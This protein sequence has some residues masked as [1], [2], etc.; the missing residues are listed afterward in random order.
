[1]L[2]QTRL[3]MHHK[4]VSHEPIFSPGMRDIRNDHFFNFCGSRHLHIIFIVSNHKLKSP[5]SIARWAKAT[6]NSWSRWITQKSELLREKAIVYLLRCVPKSPEWKGR[7]CFGSG[8]SHLPVERDPCLLVFCP[9]KLM[10]T[11]ACFI[12]ARYAQNVADS[13]FSAHSN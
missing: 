5:K 11:L 6:T 7:V 13:Y 12:L 10:A 9:V 8:Q 1:M 3:V 2:A 4:Y